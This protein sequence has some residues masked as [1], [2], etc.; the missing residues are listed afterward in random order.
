MQRK[1]QKRTALYW[2]SLTA[3]L[4]FFIG[5]A[6][7]LT[8]ITPTVTGDGHEYIMQTVA[9]QNHFSFGISPED[10]EE[11]KAQFYQNQ[12]G[13][14]STYTDPK[15][16]AFDER[17][18]AYSNHFGAYSA[19]VTVIKLILLKLNIYPL[20][21]FCIT[22]L[23]LW[24]AVLLVVFFYLKIDDKRKF[25]ILILLMLN[26]AFFYL[27]WTHTEIFI[28][29]FEV[30]G[31][32]FLYNKQYIPSILAFSISAMQN[33]G[34][35]PIG[36]MA[37]ISYIFDCYGRYAQENQNRNVLGFFAE[38]WKKILPYGF[39]YIPAFFPLIMSYYHLGTFNRVADIAMENK[40]MLHKA[41]G[42]LFDPN[43][44]IFPYEPMLMIG[45]IILIIWGLKKYPREAILNLLCIT[46]ILFIIAHQ[47]QINSGMQGIM[48][49]CV[50]I[51]PVMIFFVVFHWPSANG[52]CR[53]LLTMAVAE[54]IFTAVLV[55]YCVWFGGAYNGLRFSD[56][57]KILIDVAPQIYNPTHGIFYSRT[58]GIELY[59]SPVPVVYENEQGYV[60]KILLSKTAEAR[61]F[62]ESFVLLDE[63]KNNRIDKSTL[64]GCS[65]DEGDYTYYNFNGKVRWLK[66][67]LEEFTLGDTSDTIYFY[68][69]RYNADT[70]A[71]KGISEKEDWGCWT[72][73]KEVVLYF[74]VADTSAPDVGVYIDVCDT[75]YRPQSV[76]ALI[77]GVNVYHNTIEGDMD[78]E[79]TFENPGTDLIELT[80]LLPDAVSP[81]ETMDINDSRELGLGLLTMKVT[82]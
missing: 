18:W 26:P 48:R 40:Y 60:R 2:V 11:T 56:W 58:L 1:A 50:W 3:I 37:G 27:D 30:T 38:Y 47:L 5:S 33:V 32:V 67:G 45:F 77:N 59:D 82:Y 65:V 44:G 73:E 64:T 66:N 12:E 36:A 17:G 81:S 9:F 4:S 78:I 61:F 21:A 25:C 29:A 31:L 22:N 54:G 57:T 10:F 51:I 75:F 43:L 74:A 76:T 71:Q 14:Y 49:Y 16:I 15:C 6:V 28:F 52:K 13:L 55:S 35:L 68:S 72:D 70:F 69:E 63:E 46:G 53:G 42:Y 20:W 8:T 7:Y 41:V 62:D 23:L 80:L 79:F 19:L 39:L 24:T 34:I